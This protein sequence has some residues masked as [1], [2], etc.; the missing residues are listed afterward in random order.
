[1]TA[2]Q[3]NAALIEA[4]FVG[5]SSGGH[6]PSDNLITAIQQAVDTASKT[7]SVAEFGKQVVKN[8]SERLGGAGY[9]LTG[10]LAAAIQMAPVPPSGG[11]LEYPLMMYKGP[12][13]A[14]LTRV[15]ENREEELAAVAE[16]WSRTPAKRPPSKYPLPMVE[17]DPAHGTDYRRVL[18]HSAA[19]IATF[20]RVTNPEDWVT[21]SVYALSGRPVGLDELVAEHAAAL[22]KQIDQGLQQPPEAESASF[23]SSDAVGHEPDADA[24]GEGKE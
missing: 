22:H 2:E 18:L 4:L 12:H 17:I 13:D 5:P 8:L 15:V 23:A 10:N 9:V 7:F 16:G 6:L 1:M 20:R 21:D 24:T 19:E 3:F 14:E 11:G